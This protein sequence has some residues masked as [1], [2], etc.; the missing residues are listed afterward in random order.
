MRK[1]GGL[2]RY[3]KLREGK[4][5]CPLLEITSPEDFDNLSSY[6]QA[7]D[8]LFLELPEYLSEKSNGLKEDVDSLL[9]VHSSQNEFYREYEDEID[10]PVISGRP[11][12]E[13]LEAYR[14]ARERFGEVAVRLFLARE[15]ED[16]E[17]AEM[18]RLGHELRETD[19]AIFDLVDTV[20]MDRGDYSYLEALADI[21]S[22]SRTI[23]AN[24]MN[25]YSGE[26]Y[27]WGPETAVEYGFNGFGDF[28]VGGRYP[29]V[30]I[31]NFHEATKIVRHYG[32]DDFEINEF[33]GD[34]YEEAAQ[35]LEAWKPWRQAH[36]PFCRQLG[37]R[38]DDC[39]SHMA[40]QV[41]VGHYIHSVLE[42]DLEMVGEQT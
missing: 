23:V 10:I 14:T 1:F 18:N 13:T 16:G 5:L 11:V 2:S 30:A 38:E 12:P 8:R 7:S 33:E 20:D 32:V 31:P 34:S 19:Y 35:S 25:V 26:P 6:R 42:N 40:K 41:R 36:C 37:N 3:E 9:K 15:L 27:N 28:A 29:P 4:A 17:L 39:T 21:F 24:A 22:A